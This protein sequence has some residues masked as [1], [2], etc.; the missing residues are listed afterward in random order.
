MFDEQPKN[1]ATP[2]P[3]LPIEPS[4][5][6]AGLED[7]EQKIDKMPNALSS[8]LLKKKTFESGPP[9]TQTMETPPQPE[10]V[11]ASTQPVIGKVI[12]ILVMAAVVGGLGF[13][14]GYFFAARKLSSSP[15]EKVAA[16]PAPIFDEIPPVASAPAPVA[17]VEEQKAP[18][19]E[20]ASSVPLQMENDSILFGEPIDSDGDG[21][22][23][24]R[25]NEIGTRPDLSDT[26]NDGLKDGDEVI[27]WKTNP[28]NPD[29]DGD[30]FPDGTEVKNNYNPLG[31][32]KLFMEST[33]TPSK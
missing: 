17:P 20:S 5:M 23:D 33:S 3:N 28:L 30:K 19:E 6:F 16:A 25:E 14:G 15:A 18:T 24:V 4:D 29:S 8:G 10:S 13:A 32:G 27:V 9:R 31:P 12:V 22:D 7:E 11:A 2:P 21:L 26:D 1:E